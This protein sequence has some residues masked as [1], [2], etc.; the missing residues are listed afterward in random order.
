[1]SRKT[2]NLLPKYRLTDLNQEMIFHRLLSVVWLTVFSFVLVIGVQVYAQF[3]LQGQ[4]TSQQGELDQLKQ[5]VSK[6]ENSELKSKIKNINNLI[7]DYKNMTA[8]VPKLSKVLTA[9]SALPPDSVSINSITIDPI[10]KTV[11]V[12][13]FSPTR[14]AVLAFYNALQNDGAEFDNVDYPLQH[15]V[16]A[17]DVPFQFTFTIKDELLK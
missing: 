2:I 10:K 4:L 14:E 7:A 15:I 9:F 5:Q 3:L 11:M 8:A 16:K 12:S 1:M 17:T 13:G 6:K